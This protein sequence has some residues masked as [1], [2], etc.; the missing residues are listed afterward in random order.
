MGAAILQNDQSEQVITCFQDTLSNKANPCSNTERI[1]THYFF[2]HQ[3]WPVSPGP[4]SY[5]CRNRQQTFGINIQKAIVNSS[6]VSWNIIKNIT[7]MYNAKDRLQCS[8]WCSDCAYLLSTARMPKDSLTALACRRLWNL[9][10]APGGG[11]S[12]GT[13][14]KQISIVRQLSKWPR[15]RH[16][17]MHSQF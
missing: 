13:S 4:W 3:V 10:H 14:T 11:V 15:Y 6:K 17:Q 7:W 5:P 1:P 9:L 8:S 16:T 2:I 12:S